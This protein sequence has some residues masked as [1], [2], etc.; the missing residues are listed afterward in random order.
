VVEHPPCDLAPGVPEVILHQAVDQPDVRLVDQRLQLHHVDVA[1][2]AEA[3]LAVEHEGHPAAHPRAEVP[4]GGPEHHHHPTGHV[5]AAVV[6]DA[7]DHCRGAAV[8][9]GEAL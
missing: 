6:A 7:L 8:P 1:S 4:A 5:L 9:D 2:L 3:P